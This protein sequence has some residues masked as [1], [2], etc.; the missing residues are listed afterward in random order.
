MLRGDWRELAI[1]F[2]FEPPPIG[3]PGEFLV[4]AL[5]ALLELGLPA[6]SPATLPG[7]LGIILV[8]L[9]GTIPE[10]LRVSLVAFLTTLTVSTTG[11][12]VLLSVC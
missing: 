12:T 4:G 11:H 8:A 7:L 5:V 10:I 2:A 6:I 9:L 3:I 1:V